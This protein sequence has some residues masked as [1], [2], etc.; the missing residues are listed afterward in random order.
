M[1]RKLCVL[2]CLTAFAAAGA[3]SA[4]ERTDPYWLAPVEEELASRLYPGFA[5]LMRTPGLARIKC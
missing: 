4:Q 2:A 3:V 1:T 5:A